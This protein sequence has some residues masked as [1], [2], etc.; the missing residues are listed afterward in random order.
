[1]KKCCQYKSKTQVIKDSN[2]KVKK[3]KGIF[4]GFR[5]FAIRGN[6]F[7][8]AVGVVIGGAFTALVNALVNSVINPF[9]SA[10]FGSKDGLAS[11]WILEL[12]GSEIKFGAVI[13]AA[14]NFLIIA[15]AL[16]F[17]IILPLNKLT[18]I[19]KGDNA[20]QNPNSD[21]ETTSETTSDKNSQKS[22][23]VVILEEIRDLL[24]KK[25]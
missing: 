5:D 9:I 16:Y 11:L 15:A 2:N 18:A 13:L 3:V 10:L 14:L 22:D 23:E 1:M 25:S 20:K 4:A 21:T 8:L 7:E 24:N 17:F 6:A 12:N 19:I